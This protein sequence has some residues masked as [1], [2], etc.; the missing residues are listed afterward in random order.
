[1]PITEEIVRKDTVNRNLKDVGIQE[2]LYIDLCSDKNTDQTSYQDVEGANVLI[3][4]SQY[5]GY[6]MF[7][8]VQGYVD[9]GTGSFKLYN[10]TDSADMTNAEITTT[11]TSAERVRSSEITKPESGEK[12]VK[13]QHKITGGGG[14]DKVYSVKGRIIFVL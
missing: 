9:S 13:L 2:E 12:T 5:V 14:G 8:E 6:K 10:T 4:F 11:Q 1:M 7:L 3:D